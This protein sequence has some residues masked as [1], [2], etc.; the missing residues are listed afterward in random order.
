MMRLASNVLDEGL[1]QVVPEPKVKRQPKYAQQRC[2]TIDPNA[3]RGPFNRVRSPREVRNRRPE[4]WTAR[5]FVLPK[6]TLEG[7]R[8]L[9]IQFAQA[10]QHSNWPGGA[11]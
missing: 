3:Y 2:V 8:I 11:A 9:A 6:V 5:W 1:P 4:N 7:L 10:Q